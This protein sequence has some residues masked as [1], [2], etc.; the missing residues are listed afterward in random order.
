MW[1]VVLKDIEAYS[2]KAVAYLVLVL[3]LSVISAT[4]DPPTFTRFYVDTAY[5]GNGKPGWVRAGDIDL[6]GDMDLMAGGGGAMFSYENDGQARGWLRFGSL[7]GSGNMGANGAILHDVD[8]DGDLD[9]ICAK[10][11][12]DLG[13]WENPGGALSSS[14]WLFHVFYVN[15]GWYV[16]DIEMLDLDGDGQASEVIANLN[17]GYWNADIKILWFTIPSVNP[18]LAWSANTLEPNRA[19]G[20]PHGHA[21]MDVGDIDGDG[22]QDY[23]YSNGWYQR[24]TNGLG[25]T[26]WTWHEVT[27]FYGVSNT[28]LHDMN[29]NGRLDLLMSAGHHGDGV[30]WYANP[31]NPVSDP[32]PE[33]IIDNVIHHPEGLAIVDLD[34]DRDPDVIASELFFGE[35]PGEPGWNE[36]AHNIFYYENLGDGSNWIKWPITTNSYPS[37]LLKMAD[38]N[39]DGHLDIISESAG[40]QVI[41]YY[42]NDSPAICAPS[43][44]QYQLDVVD[45]A[46]AGNGR[47]GW[48]TAGDID[49]DG[50]KD[51]V[52]GGGTALQW[53]KAPSWTRYPIESPTDAGGNGGIL[54]DLEPDGDLDL[55]AA[56]FNGA[57]TAWLNPGG[58]SAMNTWPSIVI[59][60]AISTFNQ[61]LVAGNMDGDAD[62]ELVALYV[63][64]GIYAYDPPTNPVAGAWQRTRILTTISD[65]YVGLALGDLDDDGD[66]DVVAANAWYENVYPAVTSDW[67]ARLVFTQTVQNVV[68]HDMNHDG[69]LDV[70]GAQGF[71][72]P[73]GSLYWAE[74]PG[75][76]KLQPFVEYVVAT[77]LDGPE[78][79]WV[80]DLNNDLLPDIVTGEMETSD[81][82]G[83]QGS[84]LR[85]YLVTGL[86]ATNWIPLLLAENVGVSARIQGIDID[87]DGDIDFTADGNAEDHIYLWLNGSDCEAALSVDQVAPVQIIPAGGPFAGN[88]SVT[89]TTAT[90][91][92]TIYYTL[93][94]SEPDTNAVS[95]SVAFTLSDSTTVRARA[96]RSGYVPSPVTQAV[97]VEQQPGTLVYYWPADE[98]IGNTVSNV[99]DTGSDGTLS[100][101]GWSAEALPCGTNSLCFDGVN[102]V[103][104]LGAFDIPGSTF[105]ISFWMKADDFDTGDARLISKSTDG[106]QEADHYWMVSTDLQSGDHV[107][108]FR[109]KT[110]GQTDTLI[111]DSDVLVTGAWIHVAAVYDENQM[112]LYQD[113]SVVGSQAKSG[114]L[115]TGPSIPVALGN[116]PGSF[117]K[118]FDGYLDQVQIY[119]YALTSNE[120][121]TLAAPANGCAPLLTP[122]E[123]WITLYTGSHLGSGRDLLDDL[124]NDGC[125]NLWEWSQAG[126]PLVD[127]CDAL[128]PWGTIETNGFNFYYYRV[129]P[130]LLYDIERTSNLVHGVWLPAGGSDQAGPSNLYWKTIPLGDLTNEFFRMRVTSTN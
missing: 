16:H 8:E 25:V 12:N 100:G 34:K 83:D 85:A 93:D 15:S 41:S 107:L 127:D 74:N 130:E 61:D 120:I 42:E 110:A 66:N 70:I 47:P 28:E 105:T 20:A 6:D 60:A 56:R 54:L 49:G 91:L 23:A 55:I 44:I 52:S 72:F 36:E 67:T 81:G 45:P 87:D 46:Y 99:L 75:D 37:H 76:P 68:C 123:E 31:T 94:S 80:G 21:G 115:S 121:A 35:D 117:N 10:F 5:G 3:G 33:M 96:F 101:T 73:A 18:E 124:D 51:V 1:A 102:D 98:G 4:G 58:A 69:K 48:S 9:A 53:Y 113:G 7:D 118:P 95:Y 125:L 64:G 116:Q 108:R 11:N 40:Y 2:L 119:S 71:V 129:V 79:L 109:L 112:L 14:N 24:G 126:N 84:N 77:G 27:T 50:L 82:F 43:N 57:L 89:L 19:E 26:T 32:W 103:V 17:A 65:P 38:V 78:N 63:E 30:R 114:P 13:W 29:G 111:A 22:D 90:S 39:L 128:Q 122:Y 106:I 62:L 59:D 86:D 92:A 104:D 88:I 97:F